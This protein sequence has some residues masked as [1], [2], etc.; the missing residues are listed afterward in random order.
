[1]CKIRSS[2]FLAARSDRLRQVLVKLSTN[3]NAWLSSSSLCAS[4]LEKS[5]MSSMTVNRLRAELSTMFR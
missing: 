1:M 2:C 5:R 3:E 4:I